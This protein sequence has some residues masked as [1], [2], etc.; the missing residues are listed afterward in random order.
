MKK[1]FY[2]FLLSFFALVTY[3]SAQ[4][5]NILYQIKDGTN[6][7]DTLIYYIQ[8]PTNSVI[9]I[10]AANFSVA[11]E[12]TSG[13]TY[14][15]G[16]NNC[17]GK[18]TVMYLVYSWF[19]TIW[20]PSFTEACAIQNSMGLTYNSQTYNAR[21]SYGISDFSFVGP[22]NPLNVPANTPPI[23]AMKIAFDRG[24]ISRIYPEDETEN[25]SNQMGN[26][27]FNA[28]PYTL[29][30]MGA[31]FPVE[32]AGFDGKMLNDEQALL[33]WQTATEL[34]TD[35][36]EIE[37]SFDGT[38]RDAQ[39]IGELIAAGYSDSYTS[40]QF[41]DES[42]M[43]STMYYRIKNIDLDGESSYSSTIRLHVDNKSFSLSA[44]PNPS[45]GKTFIK[46]ESPIEETFFFSL[47]NMQGQIVWKGQADF[48][49]AFGN[50]IP[51]DMSNLP[52]GIY[53]LQAVVFDQ[54]LKDQH[55]RISK[56]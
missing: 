25:L 7:R 21:F 8:N 9:P 56:Q 6:N 15:P 20:T 19:N 47:Y 37:K 55:F 12:T 41:I 40:Y 45:S 4:S 42:L 5:L 11:F 35:R 24:L 13:H 10:R 38:F 51:L 53:T 23:V 27:S 30:V 34:N 3:S 1:Y 50:Q 22:P 31:G 33:F 44:F 32:W 52:T 46:I 48:G 16:P 54:K 2:T 43:A 17:T 28:I 26:I 39:V 36:F 18:D 14:N 29:Q 49:P